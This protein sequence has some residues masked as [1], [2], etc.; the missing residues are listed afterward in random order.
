MERVFDADAV[1]HRA[2]DRGKIHSD[3]VGGLVV[4]AEHRVLQCLDIARGGVVDDDDS[5]PDPGAARGFELAQGHVE[6]TVAAD[7][8]DWGGGRR[9]RRPDPAHKIVHFPLH[10]AVRR[11]RPAVAMRGAR[12]YRMEEA[13]QP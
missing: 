12:W 13:V 10:T 1:A 11:S 8:D 5:Q 2:G 9:R 4:A 6:A 7:C 3:E